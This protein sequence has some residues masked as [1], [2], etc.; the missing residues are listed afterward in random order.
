MAISELRRLMT[1]RDL[2]LEYIK[3]PRVTL[4]PGEQRTIVVSPPS[5]KTMIS[6]GFGL[7]G[8]GNLYLMESTPHTP[9]G[10]EDTP[11][12]AWCITVQNR[13]TE[14]AYASVGGFAAAY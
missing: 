2:E 5:G 14:P 10:A 3:A 12:W 4:Q 11:P 13:G 9:E 8:S 7:R 1:L 6:G